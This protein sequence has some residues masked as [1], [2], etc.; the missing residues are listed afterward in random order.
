LAHPTKPVTR[1]VAPILNKLR[2]I[3]MSL[4]D[5][6][7]KEA[8]GEPTFRA[9][10]KGKM[11]A[12]FSNNHH[13]DGHIGVWCPSDYDARDMLVNAHPQWFYVPPYQGPKGWIAIEL[14]APDLDWD[15]A[16]EVIVDAYRMVAHKKLVAQ[17]GS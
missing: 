8:W 17:L 4:P 6:Y 13:E 10:E 3:C 5:A 1:K 2:K 7:E 12:Q 9:G 11:F 15:L 16:R 14:S